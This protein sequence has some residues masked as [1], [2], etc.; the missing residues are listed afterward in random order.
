MKQSSG[1]RVDDRSHVICS[2]RLDDAL[3]P[4]V[5]KSPKLGTI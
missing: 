4:Q 2:R 5:K 3:S 1:N